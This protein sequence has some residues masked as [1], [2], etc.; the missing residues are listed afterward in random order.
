[1]AQ[2]PLK[3]IVQVSRAD[4]QRKPPHGAPCTRCGVC[5]IS[6]PCK[7]GAR[8]F[9]LTIGRCPA[10]I[11]NPGDDYACDLIANPARYRP[12]LV[13]EHGEKTA[14]DAAAHLIGCALGCDARINGEPADRSFYQKLKIHDRLTLDQTRAAKR[15]WR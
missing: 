8:V 6:R 13:A 4:W 3:Q 7:L 2:G 12:Q 1:M 5:C 11:G 10:L 9:G 14:Q 15:L